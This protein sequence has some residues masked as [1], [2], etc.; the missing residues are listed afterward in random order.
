MCALKPINSIMVVLC[1]LFMNGGPAQAFGEKG[2]EGPI[3]KWQRIEGLS[4]GNQ[5]LNIVAGVS[6][7]G[8][9]WSATKG[10]AQVNLQNGFLKFMV[11]GLVLSAQPAGVPNPA[12]LVIGV[13]SPG[14]TEVKGTIVCNAAE[15][16]PYANVVLVDS[17]AVPFSPTGDAHFS[18]KIELPTVCDDMAFLV[19][20]ANAGPITDLWIAH[21][22]VRTLKALHH[23]P[24]DD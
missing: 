12:G 2:E 10:W 24:E 5:P 22:A 11:K 17:E 13:P 8:F 23:H 21:G 1:V 18:G 16:F 4:I 14:A 19:R 3:V 9:E 15:P 7:V 6:S 20:V